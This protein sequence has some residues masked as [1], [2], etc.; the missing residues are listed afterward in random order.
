MRPG[1]RAGALLAAL[2]L[3]FFSPVLLSG[4]LLAPPG[5][6]LSYYY[7]GRVHAAEIVRG[8]RLPLWSPALYAGFPLLADIE[9]GALY[10]PNALFVV[11]PAPLAMNLLVVLTFLVA[12]VSTFLYCRA[13]GAADLGSLVAALSYMLSGFMVA[14]LGHV[15]I[16]Q[17]A[18]WLP[19][20][21]YFLERLRTHSTWL[22]CLGLA[23]TLALLVLGGHPQIV[24][25]CSLLL[26]LYG[27][28][29]GV[30]GQPALGRRRF[31]LRAAASVLLGALLSA[32]QWLPTL[33]LARE[34]VR[35]RLSYE[36]F[37]DYSLPPSH[38]LT[39]LFPFFLGAPSA[40]DWFQ[41]WWG[42]WTETEMLGYAGI[43]PLLLAPLALGSGASAVGRLWCAVLAIFLLLALGGNTPAA[44]WLYRLPGYNLFRAPARSLLFAQLALAILAG[45]GVTRLLS[46]RDTRRLLASGATL[47]IFLGTCVA[48]LSRDLPLTRWLVGV[49]PP[50]PERVFSV[51]NPALL[52][53]I[54]VAL[55]TLGAWWLVS[56][57]PAASPF[58]LTVLLF[59]LGLAG[60]QGF[61]R[62]AAPVI[63]D[64][65]DRV[66]AAQALRTL[67]PALDSYRVV[68]Y[69]DEQNA[70][71]PYGL[72]D[73][74]GSSSLAPA[75]HLEAL[76]GMDSGGYVFDSFRLH[77][78]HALD[79]L[80]ARYLLVPVELVRPEAAPHSQGIARTRER[81]EIRLA[82]DR[83][84]AAELTL[85]PIRCSSV[86]VTAETDSDRL[87][88]GESFLRLVFWTTSG[89]RIE[90]LLGVGPAQRSSLDPGRLQGRVELA[91]TLVV[92]RLRLESLTASPLAIHAIAF[93]DS[94]TGQVLSLAAEPTAA[95]DGRLAA[96]LRWAR[97][98][99]HG[100]PASDLIVV[101]ALSRARRL[102]Q[103][104]PVAR[105]R[106]RAEDGRLLE[107]LLRAGVDTAEWAWDRPDVRMR[108]RH[109]RATIASSSKA[110]WL[111]AGHRYRTRLAFGERLRVA[112][113]EIEYVAAGAALDVHELS[114]SDSASGSTTPLLPDRTRLE[115]D[116]GE[117]LP[118]RALELAHAPVGASTLEVVSALENAV[119]AADGEVVARVLVDLVDGTAQQH[120]LRAGIETSE[121]AWER[122]DVK[123]QVRHARASV[124]ASFPADAGGFEGH[125]YLARLDLGGERL[126]RGVRIQRGSP[127][128]G[129]AVSRLVLRSSAGRSVPIYQREAPLQLD[130]LSL[131]FTLLAGGSA[132][133]VELP[134]PPAPATAIVVVSAL[135]H[136]V[137]LRQGAAVARLSVRTDDG[138]MQEFVLRAGEHTSEWAWGDPD[139]RAHVRHG[140]AEIALGSPLYDVS[141]GRDYVARFELAGTARVT[142]VGLTQ[143]APQALLSVTSL[144]LFDGATGLSV[145]VSVAGARLADGTRWRLRAEAG[146]VVVYEN[147]HALPR[148]WLVPR[149]AALAAPDVL[150][151]IRTGLL[152]DG[153][154]FDP[155]ALALVEQGESREFGSSDPDARIALGASEP[156]RLAIA[157][158]SRAPAF[159]VLGESFHPG[160][161]ATLDGSAVDILRTDYLL[162]GL[163]LPAGA[164]RIELVYDPASLRVGAALCAAG[165]AALAT[166]ALCAARAGGARGRR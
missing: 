7:A 92:E 58:A 81:Y 156:G 39:F 98:A 13:I 52:V 47:L 137:S 6:G 5:D 57:K 102:E 30:V 78:G 55:A 1:L 50:D 38:L 164:H 74:G 129:F 112:S 122:P 76:G 108:V 93:E 8:G 99:A 43:A 49:V 143:L 62:S 20:S 94:G 80:G 154:R 138:R 165:L 40:G 22:Q 149:S 42:H 25:G 53:P 100:I 119:L 147:L 96:S 9:V 125:W 68:S 136:S 37:I 11:L 105:V 132:A 157:S 113:V 4:R 24:A 29:L 51:A 166:W 31:V 91:E 110:G 56:R 162:R 82:A 163:A 123:A 12:G 32:P 88:E 127:S 87:H 69:I 45:L 144:S 107:R 23:L 21:L 148:A 140:Q 160:W 41:A 66:P 161:Q 77:E 111:Y 158:R 109:A 131:P 79:L 89:R 65:P 71:I 118:T 26:A 70:L 36:A 46:K 75:R 61:W 67:D 134:L 152:P 97:A 48:M 146:A 128:A 35:T 14:H 54:L 155:R 141:S 95:L 86:R 124:F 103:G 115:P 130:D 126:V 116:P 44:A 151:A 159:L 33:E 90:S 28:A 15:T 63:Q 83:L 150:R 104:Q 142:G 64:L 59:D 72:K 60:E 16:V 101:S 133:A 153:S 117:D 10:P 27:V 34:S 17:A 19:L 121:W 18:A 106:V 120:V 84:D 2:L 139:V 3:L 85:P 73:A 135:R 114:L 145:P